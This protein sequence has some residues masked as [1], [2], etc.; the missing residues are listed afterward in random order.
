M[1]RGLQRENQR[2][3][4]KTIKKEIQ[5]VEEE[6]ANYSSEICIKKLTAGFNV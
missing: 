4:K 5:I 1:Y 6:K 2:R 3:K